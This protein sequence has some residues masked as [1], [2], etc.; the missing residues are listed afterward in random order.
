MALATRVGHLSATDLADYLVGKGVPFREA[1]F[2]TGKAVALAEAEGCDLSELP[3]HAL[4]SVDGRIEA[5]V[6]Q[7]L[8]LTNSMNARHSAGGT[9]QEPVKKQLDYFQRWIKEHR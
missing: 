7:A 9:G 6:L 2:I 3:A 5:D 8:D 1:H 4:Q